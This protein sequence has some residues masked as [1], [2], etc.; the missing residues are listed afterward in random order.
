[1]SQEHAGGEPAQD[2][3][4]EA[5]HPDENHVVSERRVKLAL[6]RRAG[7]PSSNEHV[8][9]DRAAALYASSAGTD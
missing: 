2:L 8:P 1:M 5:A 4:S 6:L 7:N 3:R 9:Q